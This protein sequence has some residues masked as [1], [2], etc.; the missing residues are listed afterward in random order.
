MPTATSS[1][2]C[3]CG[4]KF[5]PPIELKDRHVNCPSCGS[6]IF[7]AATKSSGADDDEEDSYGIKKPGDD[8]QEKKKSAGVEGIPDWLEHYQQSPDVK[9]SERVKTLA[10]IERLAAVNPTLDPLG[11]ALYLASTHADAETSVAAL[12]KVATSGHPVYAPV[13]I[14]L[15]GHIGPSD[16]AGAQHVLTLLGECGEPAAEQLVTKVILK[17][18]PTSIVHVR[19]LIDLLGS[20]HTSLYMWAVQCLKLIG[21]PARRAVDTLLKSLKIANHAFRIA[22]IDALGAIAGD[23]EHVL[24]VLLQALK[25][26]R[27]EY[28]AH[29]AQALG[30]FGSP[31][32]K[33]VPQ[34]KEALHDA[35]EVVRQSATQALR[36]I[37]AAAKGPAT[38]AATAEHPVLE[39]VVIACSCGKRL[40]AKPELAGKKV[41]CPGCG[42]VLVVPKPKVPVAAEVEPSP[43]VTSVAEKECPTCL[44]TVPGAAV[45]CVCCGFDFRH[46]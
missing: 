32:A 26:E 20:K 24:P 41:K 25:H 38:T 9:K 1:I 15:L 29:A 16:A 27:P 7:L 44:A 22:V 35:E 45:L 13:A 28:R 23:I 8:P 39:P 3:H 34:L 37:A 10:M 14:A 6:V 12:T 18:G 31:A 43:A 17:L 46:K 11:A 40:K 33:A 19:S 5:E 36:L 30:R 42:G 2:T 21:H 4:T